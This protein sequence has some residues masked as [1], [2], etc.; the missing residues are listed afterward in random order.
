MKAETSA[1]KEA[2]DSPAAENAESISPPTE[3]DA[4][5]VDESQSL[6]TQ[7]NGESS[8]SAETATLQASSSSIKSAGSKDAKQPP[9]PAKDD[10]KKSQGS[11]TGKI[12]NLVTTDLG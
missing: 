2:A 1:G 4:G 3:S 12:N 5:T 11:L 7:E 10:A 9:K 8:S 6:A